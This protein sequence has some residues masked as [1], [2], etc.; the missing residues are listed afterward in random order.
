MHKLT[1]YPL[2]NADSYLLELEKGKKIL[3]DFANKRDPEDEADKRIDLAAELRSILDESDR[4]YFDVVAFTHA[5]DDHIHG[6]SDFFYLEWADKYKNG[7]RIKIRE[8]WVP[9]AMILEDGLED[10]AR[11]LRM[12]AR[13]RLR[14]GEGIRVFSRPDALKD[15]LAKEGIKLEDRL[16]LITNA[17]TVVPGLTKGSDG[18][19]FFAHSPF[20]KHCDEGEIDR[21]TGCL[22]LQATFDTETKLLLT[23][24]IEYEGWQDIVNITRAHGN[25]ERLAWDILKIP[26]HCSYGS[27][28]PDK[29]KTKTVPV[30]EVAWLLDQGRSG[31][32][33]VVT[34]DPI[35]SADETQPPHYQAY[36]CYEDYKNKHNGKMHVTMEWPTKDKPEKLVINVDCAGGATVA[37]RIA[38]PSII[39]TGRPSR[40]G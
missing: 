31:A 33:M 12:E 23:A 13:H 7:D 5:D 8:L 36:N 37:K 10:D 27:L 19:E 38:A 30:S 28:G 15:W 35:P 39:V 20:S 34:S 26:H 22:A 18:I 14:Q 1:F 17:G 9:A 21:N 6:A 16:H 24:D 29:G 25:D 32:V 2:G 40:A 3:F 4:D 11:I